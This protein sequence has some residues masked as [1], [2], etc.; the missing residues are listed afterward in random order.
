MKSLAQI[1]AYY[2]TTKSF[3]GVMLRQ[4]NA[5]QAHFKS[6][7]KLIPFFQAL[8]DNLV[9]LLPS[10]EIL[11]AAQ[12]LNAKLFWP[13]LLGTRAYFKESN[14]KRLVI[15]V[16]KLYVSCYLIKSLMTFFSHQLQ[17]YNYNCTNHLFHCQ[18]K[19]LFYYCLNCDQLNVKICL[20]GTNFVWRPRNC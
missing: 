3:T 8:C 16:Q 15:R 7:K 5:D 18:L 13:G 1:S 20:L 10:T 9:K 17:S 6:I 19:I 2:T 11:A 4:T 12:V 14:T